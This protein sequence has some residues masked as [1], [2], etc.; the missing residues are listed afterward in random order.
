MKSARGKENDEGI[1]HPG[2]AM[3]T[4]VGRVYTIVV[5]PRQIWWSTYAPAWTP[6]TRESGVIGQPALRHLHVIYSRAT[7]YICLDYPR[8][9]L[10]AVHRFVPLD[11]SSP[12]HTATL[13]WTVF[14][15]KRTRSGSTRKPTNS[16][17]LFTFMLALKSYV[18]CRPNFQT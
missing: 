1:E 14:F 17:S 10:V 18:N 11:S 4:V 8:N 15:L 7:E 16:F 5:L 9:K 3:D 13:Y 2:F 6:E 12:G